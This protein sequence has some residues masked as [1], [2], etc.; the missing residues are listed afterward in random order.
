MFAGAQQQQGKSASAGAMSSEEIKVADP[1]NLVLRLPSSLSAL[2]QVKSGGLRNM[3]RLRLASLAFAEL[4]GFSVVLYP[5]SDRAHMSKAD[6]ERFE[7]AI[8]VKKLSQQVSPEDIVIINLKEASMLVSASKRSI[9]FRREDEHNMELV[10]RSGA[11]FSTWSDALAR[12]KASRDV[13][14]ADFHIVRPL[15]QGAGG[16]VFLVRDRESGEQLALKCVEKAVVTKTSDKMRHAMDERLVLELSCDHPFILQLRYAFQTERRLYMVTDFCKGGDLYE[17]MRKRG[18]PLSERR[19]RRLGAQILLALEHIHSLQAIYRDL[20]L[21]NVL[22]DDR[23]YTR[24]ADFGLAKVL[25]GDK[26]GN[27]TRSYSSP[28]APSLSGSTHSVSED[29]SGGRSS[30]LLPLSGASA[31][32]AG[33]GKP[34]AAKQKTPV[35]SKQPPPPQQQ[36]KQAS[37]WGTTTFCGTREYVAPEMLSGKP[38]GQSIDVWAFGILMYEVLCGRTPFYA[39]DRDEVY[40]KI[41]TGTLTFPPHLHPVTMD[42]LT[43]L[44]HKDAQSR[45]GAGPGG[46][47]EVKGHPFFRGLDWQGVIDKVEHGDNLPTIEVEPTD[48]DFEEMM[49]GITFDLEDT[50]ESRAANVSLDKSAAGS[51]AWAAFMPRSVSAKSSRSLKSSPTTMSRSGKSIVSREF[52]K[53]S[54]IPGYAYS[55]VGKLSEDWGGSDITREGIEMERGPRLGTVSLRSEDATS[56]DNAPRVKSE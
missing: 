5:L 39:E 44:L 15:G 50:C 21:E 56:A 7:N 3:L 16:K 34:P 1:L 52:S 20:K 14:L 6:M 55:Y 2:L 31:K 42:L 25:E 8:D 49:T 48:Q 45:L 32:S 38:Y 27:S 43:K 30:A 40:N 4:R 23:G 41:E 22:L 12:A 11:Q 28:S 51:K 54:S 36:Q 33:A 18:R 35:T 10:L 19:A 13:S 37:A 46:I 53:K 26:Q 9:L 29:R 17:Y 47:A 24:I